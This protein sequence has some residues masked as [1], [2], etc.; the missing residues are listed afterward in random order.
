MLK[1]AIFATKLLQH[2]IFPAPSVEYLK[3]N[4]HIG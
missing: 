2:G 4:F 1:I 3:E